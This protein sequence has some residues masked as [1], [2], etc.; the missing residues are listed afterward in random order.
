M[1]NTCSVLT[2][3][4]VPWNF[5]WCMDG[6]QFVLSA[7][8]QNSIML[9]AVNCVHIHCIQFSLQLSLQEENV[10][11]TPFLQCVCITIMI[12]CTCITST[13][14]LQ[15]MSTRILTELYLGCSCTCFWLICNYFHASKLYTVL[16]DYHKTDALQATQM[17]SNII[18]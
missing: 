10:T 4:V 8:D 17:H 6:V 18:I 14:L 11:Y 9:S 3:T 1:Y 16:S 13:V 15:E 5:M 12:L 7:L 2:H